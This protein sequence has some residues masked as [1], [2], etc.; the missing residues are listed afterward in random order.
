MSSQRY[1]KHIVWAV[2]ALV[3]AWV[4]YLIARLGNPWVSVG[5]VAFVGLI[6]LINRLT[7]KPPGR[8]GQPAAERRVISTDRDRWGGGASL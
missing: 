5:I 8:T 4:L 7:W 3:S 2:P 1:I 6:V